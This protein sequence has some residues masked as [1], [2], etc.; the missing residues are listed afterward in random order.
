ML[1]IY[2]TLFTAL[3]ISAIAI[4]YSVMGL[5]AIFA[6]AVVPIIVMGGV[7]EVSKL[8]TVVWLHYNWEY[9]KWWLKSYLSIAVILI[10]II[11]SIGIFGT[12][13]KSHIEQT[14]L[15]NEQTARIELIE[16]QIT[17][18][19]LKIKRW[20]N[21]I[22]RLSNGDVGT[23]VDN[24]ITRENTA[25]AIINNQ[26]V[27]EQSQINA[28]ISNEEEGLSKIRASV[29]EDKEALRERL[30]ANTDAE[31]NRFGAIRSSHNT[32]LESLNKQLNNC[33]SCADEREAIITEKSEFD[34]KE[35][36]FND[37]IIIMRGDMDQQIN[38][39]GQTY[40]DQI[41]SIMKRID[42]LRTQYNTV[43]NKYVEQIAEINSR[44]KELKEQSNTKTQTIDTRI[45]SLEENIV[46]EQEEVG[47]VRIEKAVFETQYR[48]LKADVGPLAYVAEL[49]YEES[50]ESVLE[51][52]VRVLIIV[53]I[54]VFDPLAVLLLIASQYSFERMRE[55]MP[56]INNEGENEETSNEPASNINETP[57]ND[58]RDPNPADDSNPIVPATETPNPTRRKVSSNKKVAKKEAVKKASKEKELRVGVTSGKVLLTQDSPGYLTYK[59]KVSKKEAFIQA[60]L[61][62]HLD[63]KSEVAFGE[64]LPYSAKE[65]SFYIRTDSLPTKLFRYNGDKWDDID[66]R[67]LEH[68]A[69]SKEY[70]EHLIEKMNDHK[71]DPVLL[72]AVLEERS[73]KSPTLLNP[74]E[75]K[76]IE[77]YI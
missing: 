10:M 49:I 23:R 72:D 51:E 9:A 62:L 27:N 15:S 68:S 44:I 76:H 52:A 11:T 46:T 71:N 38:A 20:S 29:S 24:L 40:K 60:H 45:S 65:G 64:E 69:Y 42:I 17:R 41:K 66:K 26:I 35:Q 57:S 63:F 14:L 56:F 4:Y 1:L 32:T 3:S 28:T 70:I 36:L 43:K 19:A 31:E 48:K 13:S 22:N 58:H 6:G 37:K 55:V 67:L 12:L 16:E 54:F 39:V 59:N 8:V 47:K 73:K 33:F 25:L 74:A 50:T 7:L 5:A 34:A 75:L 2:I 53:I 18:S 21:E 30:Q 77:E 61:G